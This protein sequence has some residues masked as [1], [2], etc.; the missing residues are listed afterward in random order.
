MST[1][2]VISVIIPIY[3]SEKYLAMTLDSLLT[4]SIKEPYEIICVY[5]EST[6]NTLE[7]LTHYQQCY[8]EIITIYTLDYYCTCS[9]KR[10]YGLQRARGE[11]VYLCDSDDIVQTQALEVLYNTAKEQNADV[12][13]GNH[14]IIKT[15]NDGDIVSRSCAKVNNMELSKE[16]SVFAANAFW[17]TLIK[18]ELC[19]RVGPIP[20]GYILDDVAYMTALRT[21]ANKIYKISTPVY[22]WYSRT[23]S[24]STSLTKEKCENYVMSEK[25]ALEKANPKYKYAVQKYVCQRI[26][27]NKYE[28]WMYSD[29]FINWAKELWPD[30]KDNR[31]ILE[32]KNLYYDI[33]SYSE[34]TFFEPNVFINGFTNTPSPQRIEELREKAFHTDCNVV[35]LSADN[36]NLEENPYIKQAYNDGNYEL[37]GGYFVLKS[38]YENGGIFIHDRIRILNYFNDCQYLSSF[39]TFLDK[40]SYSDK[41]FGGKAGSDVI[42]SILNTFSYKWDKKAD[43]MSLAERIKIIL[44]A[45]YDVPLNG[46]EL[47]NITPVRIFSPQNCVVNPLYQNTDRWNIVKNLCEHDF[48]DMAGNEEYVTLKR[49]TLDLLLNSSKASKSAATPPSKTTAST[50]EKAL[51]KELNDIKNS[52]TYK[53]AMRIKKFANSKFGKP[54]KKMFKWFLKKYRKHKYGIG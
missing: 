19:D 21:Y 32:D 48:T 52:D 23:N 46:E 7:I 42:G 15:N 45:K 20:S 13:Q 24:F 5:G 6:D 38:I 25:Y 22:Y 50:R 49:S 18:K 39:F 30:I 28:R 10:N 53:G 17:I 33:K 12:V 41:V 14:Y 11:Y 31:F 2:P 40:S 27:G 29:V 9:E 34:Y 4:Q 3:N 36:C 8:P 43:F 26:R 1:T 54:F 51:Q 44:T 47:K 16:Q 35:V 37:V